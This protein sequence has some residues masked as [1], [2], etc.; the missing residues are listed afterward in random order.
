MF[1]IEL[2]IN[3]V[4]FILALILP[5]KIITTNIEI[6]RK[7]SHILCGN[8]IFIFAFINKYFYTNVIIIVFMIG[9]MSVSYRYNIFKSVER[10]EQ[11]KSFGTIYFFVSLFILVLLCKLFNL[12]REFY[13]IY[14]FPLVYGDAFAAIVGKK[15]NWIEYKVFSGKKTVSGNITM[16]SISLFIIILY[17][18]FVLENY[19]TLLY[20]LIITSFATLMEAFSVKGIDNFTIPII[21]MCICEVIF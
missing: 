6:T 16:F 14:F 11:I 3:F 4:Y 13:I 15:I 17:N 2:S 7:I 1:V 19:Y 18:F 8:W 21:T 20:L 10:E 12:N 9:L 5:G